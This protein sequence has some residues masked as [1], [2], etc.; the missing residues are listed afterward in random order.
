M[1]PLNLSL[2]FLPQTK[3]DHITTPYEI[4]YTYMF[5]H[6]EPLGAEAP[7]LVG[8]GGPRK[9]GGVGILWDTWHMGSEPET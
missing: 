4:R 8:G 3:S 6:E 7:L 2:A 5:I 9:R 1:K